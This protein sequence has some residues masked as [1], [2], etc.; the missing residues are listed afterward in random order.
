MY[1]ATL[2]AKS[3]SEEAT[4]LSE[5][6]LFGHR[7][8][9]ILATFVACAGRIGAQER[10]FA[11]GEPQITVVEP[12]TRVAGVR[13]LPDGR[14]VV[15][16]MRERLIHLVD[17]AGASL[18]PLG[19]SG[20]GPLEFRFP[21]GIARFPGDTIGI[22]DPTN[23]RY[24]KISPQGRIVAEVSIPAVFL[25]RG[26]LAPPLGVDAQGRIY[27]LGDVVAMLPSGPK[28]NQAQNVR[29]WA[30]PAEKLDTVAA[31]SD[32]APEMHAHRFHPYAERDAV[33]IARDGRVG[34]LAARDYRLRWFIDGREVAAGPALSFDRVA[35]TASDRQ[36]Y[37]DERARNPA[38]AMMSGAP[39]SSEPSPA[40][41]RQMA[42]A[43]PDVIFPA[44]M[45]PFVE[46][47]AMLSPSEDVWVTRSM[48]SRE[49]ARR[50]DI[51]ANDGRRN[52]HLMLPAD[53]RLVALERDG[54]YLARTDEDG[55][56]WVERYAW[57]A[58]LR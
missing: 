22:Y 58:G 11:L 31:A 32:H 37:R 26:G 36:A 44:S 43:Y 35:V 29:R 6:S 56:E 41:R 25:S 27:W 55:F 10:T 50:I 21:A 24:L 49:R 13:E 47:G 39:R 7:K 8:A 4:A 28:R 9:L 45:P 15:V 34:V 38:G 23:R 17:R 20:E 54:V 3:L 42:E 57:P 30:P 46:G 40:A 14:F 52:G 19:T 51:L 5:Q 18:T 12:F 2:E 53:R 16:D 48:A 1:S 33:V